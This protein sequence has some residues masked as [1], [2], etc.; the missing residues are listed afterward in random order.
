MQWWPKDGWQRIVRPLAW[1]VLVLLL[2]RIGLRA[3]VHSVTQPASREGEV[4]AAHFDKLEQGVVVTDAEGE[5]AADFVVRNAGQ[6]RLVV[7]LLRR[8][9]CD[10]PAPEPL[11]LDPGAS[12]KLTVRASAADL[13]KRGEYRQALTTN[14]P[15]SP[16]VW[17][18]LKLANE[19]TPAIRPTAATLPEGA[20]RSVLVKRP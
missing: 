7:R 1:V 5:V 13:L 20:G 9:C 16:E 14:D 10:P 18:T 17:L 11:I 8:A 3:A 12:G 6:H 15:R 2:A 4:A 19:P